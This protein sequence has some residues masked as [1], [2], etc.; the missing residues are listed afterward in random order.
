[1][2]KFCEQ[3][4]ILKDKLERLEA[5]AASKASKHELD[6]LEEKISVIVNSED[7]GNVI[8]LSEVSIQKVVKLSFHRQIHFH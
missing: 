7:R 1:M 3:G 2:V 6:K 8:S 5:M 4:K